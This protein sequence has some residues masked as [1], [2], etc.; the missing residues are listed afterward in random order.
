MQR[1]D[2]EVGS[3]VKHA[4]GFELE[5]IVSCRSGHHWWR[6]ELDV[7]SGEPLDDLHVLH[8]WGSDKDNPGVDP[9]DRHRI[10]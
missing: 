9:H 6:T 3:V 2:T 8:T 5:R 4:K 7:G 10:C 1:Q